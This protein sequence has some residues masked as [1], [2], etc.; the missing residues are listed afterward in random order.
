M[1]VAVAEELAACGRAGDQRLLRGWPRHLRAAKAQPELLVGTSALSASLPDRL[2]GLEDFL[3]GQACGADKDN[4]TSLCS[5]SCL[6]TTMLGNATLGTK[7]LTKEQ[8]VQ[9]FID[10]FELE[11]EGGCPDAVPSSAPALATAVQA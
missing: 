3:C 6:F 2:S 4:A 9:P 8:V 1:L 11:S 7:P 10:A 5:V